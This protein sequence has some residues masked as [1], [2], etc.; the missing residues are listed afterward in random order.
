M[1]RRRGWKG[2]KKTAGPATGTRAEASAGAGPS[3]T[4]PGGA[5]RRRHDVSTKTGRSLGCLNRQRLTPQVSK[6]PDPHAHTDT[7]RGPPTPDRPHG[8]TQRENNGPSQGPET[9][10][11][12][13]S[14]HERTASPASPRTHPGP[15]P[16]PLTQS[17]PGPSPQSHP[18]APPG[19]MWTTRAYARAATIAP[20]AWKRWNSSTCMPS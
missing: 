12:H 1:S 9:R 7:H 18:Q 5:T 4:R 17:R 8:H 14:E 3:G 19:Q 11:A 16:S 20:C 2:T 10:D 13:R 15:S 6:S